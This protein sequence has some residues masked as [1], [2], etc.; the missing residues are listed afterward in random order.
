MEKPFLHVI[1]LRRNL[2]VWVRRHGIPERAI[3]P[4][5]RRRV[6]HVDVFGAFAEQL[7]ERHRSA[8]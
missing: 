4:E 3:Q 1:G 5:K 7:I 6:A 2:E 8:S